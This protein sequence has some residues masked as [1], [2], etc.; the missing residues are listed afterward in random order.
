MDDENLN[1]L[2]TRQLEMYKMFE[3]IS[4]KMGKWNMGNGAD[5]AH[6]VEESPFIAEG[7]ICGNCAFYK[8]GQVCDIVEGD[9]LISPLA[10]CKL[11][12]I[13]ESLIKEKDA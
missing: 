2:K 5:G 4:A 13:R 7:M 11:W 1:G 3:E 10:I 8:G 9:G 12:V 6:Y